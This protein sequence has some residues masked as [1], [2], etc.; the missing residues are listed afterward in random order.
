MLLWRYNLYKMRL[1]VGTPA[2]YFKD[3]G[4]DEDGLTV[5]RSTMPYAFKL[6]EVNR[7]IS[8]TTLM[9]LQEGPK[10]MSLDCHV[11]FAA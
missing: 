3:R 9:R 5:D 1:L 2:I 11:L 6:T 7:R 4:K 10:V 8:T